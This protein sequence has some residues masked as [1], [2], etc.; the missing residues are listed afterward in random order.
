MPIAD[1]AKG[2][3][4]L[5]LLIEQTGENRVVFDY[6]IKA[7]KFKDQKIKMGF[8]VPPDFNLNPPHGPHFTPRL[9]PINPSSPK[10]TE[11]VHESPFGTD[12]EHLSRPFPNWHKSRRTVKEYM[13]Y[14][15]YLFEIL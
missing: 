7:G 13:R 2:L 3:Q 14:M 5:G 1:F 10:H 11:R 8:E 12:W 4:E 6:V 9:L 15:D